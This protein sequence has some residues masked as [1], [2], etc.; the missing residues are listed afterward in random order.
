MSDAVAKLRIRGNLLRGSIGA[1][2][3]A[4]AIGGVYVH[5]KRATPLDKAYLTLRDLPQGHLIRAGDLQSQ[6][7]LPAY[8]QAAL[9]ALPAPLGRYMLEG[10]PKQTAI[11]PESLTDYPQVKIAQGNYALP[12]G[13][14]P[15][16][17]ALGILDVE[18]K[19]SVCASQCE[20]QDLR[21]AA[22][23]CDKAGSVCSVIFEVTKDQAAVISSH[24]SD[25]ER[26][27]VSPPV[28]AKP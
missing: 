15:S 2:Y 3:F 18:S 27:V 17:I 25:Q 7:K 11:G 6:S 21:V 16:L 19:V 24:P 26:L 9:A 5:E 12:F 1:L 14:P 13:V 10:A 28:I 4:L 20:A 22:T 23:L 8:R